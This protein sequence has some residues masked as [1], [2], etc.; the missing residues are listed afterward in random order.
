MSEESSRGISRRKFIVSS[1]AAGA[2]AL[3]G[4]TESAGSGGGGGTPTPSGDGSDGSSSDG[5]STGSG[6][7]ETL[8]GDI[9]IAGSSTVYPLA[10]AVAERFMEKHPD[11]NVTVQ[12]TGS[13]GGF[14]NFFCVGKTAFNNASRPIKDSEKQLCRDNGVEWHEIKVATDAVTVVVNNENDWVDCMTVDELKQIWKPDPAMKWS[15]VNSEWPDKKIERYGAA[16]TSGTFDYFTEAVMGEEGAH[17]SDYQPTEKDNLIMQG[18][19]GSKYAIGYF[20]FA[21][22]SSNPDKAKALAIDNGSGCVKPSLDTAK[23]G[24]Y[25]PLS[26]PLFTYPAKSELKKDHVAEFARFFIEQ[27]AN[28]KLVADTVGYVPNTKQRMQK[29]LEQLN[30]T[31]KSVQ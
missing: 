14:S 13:G 11:V 4:C 5:G 3:A 15:D 8:S 18:V 1:G 31:I 9:P 29:E 17:T 26:R 28:E 20:G 16:E 12:S 6:S 30:E 25:K 24:E 23:S 22:Y 10:T 2:V 19:T 27:S 21:Y 7:D